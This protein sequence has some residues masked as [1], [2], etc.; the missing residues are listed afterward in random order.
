MLYYIMYYHIGHILGL[1]RMQYRILYSLRYH[2]HFLTSLV[3]CKDVGESLVR[4]GRVM[5]AQVP[6]LFLLVLN[7]VFLSTY[8]PLRHVQYS[9]HHDQ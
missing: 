8:V 4:L 9:F 2:M 1:Y 5:L 6:A 3:A 7:T